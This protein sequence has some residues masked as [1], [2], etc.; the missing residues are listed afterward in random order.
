MGKAFFKTEDYKNRECLRVL[1]VRG[2]SFQRVCKVSDL[3]KDSA[4]EDAL[5]SA[6]IW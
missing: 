2:E 1:R 4:M 3:N 6:Y 5:A